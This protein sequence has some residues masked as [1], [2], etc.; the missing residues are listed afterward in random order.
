VADRC[1]V[2]SRSGFVFAGWVV[3]LGAEA[4]C[5]GCGVFAGVALVGD[6]DLA[7]AQ[8][9]RQQSER[10]VLIKAVLDNPPPP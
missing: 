1:Q 6:D 3:D 2:G 5:H 8:A 10:G 7:A 4:P 9:E